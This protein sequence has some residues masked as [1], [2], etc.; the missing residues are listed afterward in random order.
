[1]LVCILFNIECV[2]EHNFHSLVINAVL[3]NSP[4]VTERDVEDTIKSWLKHS[5]GRLKGELGKRRNFLHLNYNE[6][7]RK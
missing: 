5:P 3:N 7:N 6:E 4:E 1:M 2:I